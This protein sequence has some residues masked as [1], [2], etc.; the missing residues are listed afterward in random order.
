MRRIKDLTT[1]YGR[2]FRVAVVAAAVMAT[3][4]VLSANSGSRG[5]GQDRDHGRERLPQGSVWVVNRDA[6]DLTVFD[7]RT[8]AVLAGRSFGVGTA[9][10]DIC[11]SERFK[12]A[13]V[14]VEAINQ[15]AVVDLRTLKTKFIPVAPQP[16]HCEVSHDGETLY[17]SLASHP[18]TPPVPAAPLVAVI[19]LD[20]NA[21]SY[22]TSSNDPAARSHGLFAAPE[23]D[24]LFVAHDTGNALTV[25]DLETGAIDLTI[26]GILRAEEP[27]ATRYGNSLWVSARGENSVKLID[28]DTQEV[29]T[30]PITG[31]QPES[32]MLTP[33]ER[34]LAVT[35][36]GSPAALALV[37]AVNLES[38]G[39]IVFPLDGQTFGDLGVMTR[40]GR[41]VYATYDR[42]IP[43]SGGVAII[44]V[45]RREF[46]DSFDYPTIGRPHGIAITRRRPH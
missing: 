30:I 38:L 9:P 32:V 41:Y 33:S 10:H 44:D 34:T 17:V 6:G 43:G 26:P 23:G 20:T 13:Y 35:L 36:R 39:S 16:H 14:T 7:A 22:I 24:K 5:G 4:P 15:V 1:R 28:L 27:V 40:D 18:S 11:I 42:G 46:V 12:K 2:G 25:V 21:V 31:V 37:D 3:I 8:G 19:D 29:K 45:R